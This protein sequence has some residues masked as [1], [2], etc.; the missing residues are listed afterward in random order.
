MATSDKI[1]LC[2]IELKMTQSARVTFPFI[3]LL[4]IEAKLLMTSL[5]QL[6]QKKRLVQ[7]TSFSYT[8]THR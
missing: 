6:M 8:H 2:G 3:S 7:I 4:S 1:A 5:A